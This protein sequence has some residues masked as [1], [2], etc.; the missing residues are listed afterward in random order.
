[1]GIYIDSV[2]VCVLDIVRDPN[3]N[4]DLDGI[5]IQPPTR[6]AYSPGRAGPG[7]AQSG[8]SQVAFRWRSCS[9]LAGARRRIPGQLHQP[10]ACP[11][12]ARKSAIG[13]EIINHI[14]G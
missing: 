6:G 4:G 1:M 12:P 13:E 14:L 3:P 9:C 10:N 11:N 8:R 2:C 5:Q 7:L